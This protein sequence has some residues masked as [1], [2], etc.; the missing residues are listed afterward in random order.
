MIN[1]LVWETKREKDFFCKPCET[2][3]YLKKK[4]GGGKKKT[5]NKK[6]HP[7]S[8]NLQKEQLIDVYA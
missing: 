7:I 3:A 2:V 6:G 8:P 4:G 1:Q 5:Q